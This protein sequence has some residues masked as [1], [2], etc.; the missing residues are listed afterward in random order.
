MKLRLTHPAFLHPGV[1]SNALAMAFHAAMERAGAKQARVD[2][3]S[4][5]ST[6]ILFT[7][8]W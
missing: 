8:G 6:E 1:T 7:I 5:T 4:P 2:V 3:A